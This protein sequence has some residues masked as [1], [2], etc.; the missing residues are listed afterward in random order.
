LLVSERRQGLQIA[1][2]KRTAPFESH[3]S[4]T[5]EHDEAAPECVDI[6]LEE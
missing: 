4:K 2:A 5:L 3:K 6:D 1:N